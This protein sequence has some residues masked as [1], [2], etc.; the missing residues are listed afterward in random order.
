MSLSRGSTMAP[1]DESAPDPAA[2]PVPP[3]RPKHRAGSYEFSAD[4]NKLLSILSSKMTFVGLFGLAIGILV[5][6]A[7]VIHRRPGAILSG[8]FY[9]VFGIWTHRAGVSLRHIVDTEGS[10]IQHLMYAI[11]DLRKL[12]T[13]QYWICL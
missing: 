13:V 4:Q 3:T 1:A 11:E 7:G 10:D 8:A 9:A 2:G 12:Y 5:I 6:I